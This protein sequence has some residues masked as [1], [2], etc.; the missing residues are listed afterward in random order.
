MVDQRPGTSAVSNV[1]RRA[2]TFLTCYRV[3]SSRSQE[4]PQ[5]SSPTSAIYKVNSCGTQ[6]FPLEIA[7]YGDSYASEST[8]RRIREKSP[9]THHA[10][11]YSM[12]SAGLHDE[13]VFDQNNQ[14]QLFSTAQGCSRSARCLVCMLPACTRTYALT[15]DRPARAFSFQFFQAKQNQTAFRSRRKIIKLGLR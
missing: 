15:A 8:T 5:N 9:I 2:R 12:A 6:L 3:H 1:S 7:E 10:A 4:N 14:G 11:K 13:F